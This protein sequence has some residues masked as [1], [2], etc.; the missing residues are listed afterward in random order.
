M[1][2]FAT[3]ES[4]T[5]YFGSRAQQNMLNF[6]VRDLDAMLAHCV[7]RE[8]TWP[9]RPRT[10]KA[11]VDSVGSLIPRAI[12]WSCGSPPDRVITQTW[13]RSGTIRVG[14]V[15]AC[16]ETRCKGPHF[17]SVECLGRPTDCLVCVG[18][19]VSP[20]STRRIHGAIDGHRPLADQL[21]LR[22]KRLRLSPRRGYTT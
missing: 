5:D 20:R 6:R 9:R 10:W 16:A 2:V 12:G 7:P 18:H 21:W 11:S 19:R 13:G 3:F 14:E 8:R 1:T 22:A 15:R 17:P 4:E